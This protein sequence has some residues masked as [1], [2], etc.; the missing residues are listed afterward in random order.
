[1]KRD[2]ETPKPN[3]ILNRARKAARQK[4]AEQ[5]KTWATVDRLF[6]RDAETFGSGHPNPF[7][8]LCWCRKW[9]DKDE[10]REMLEG[11]T[12]REYL[13]DIYS[14]RPEDLFE[15]GW[16]FIERA[17][18]KKKEIAGMSWE[19]VTRLLREELPASISTVM[20]HPNLEEAHANDR[21]LGIPDFK[22]RILDG[23]INKPYLSEEEVAY[24]N[25]VAEVMEKVEVHP[26]PMFLPATY[27]G[28]P[29]PVKLVWKLMR[30][31]K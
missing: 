27:D 31:E 30:D 2:A 22:V 14:M 15:G 13:S 8:V 23:L 1:M 28:T 17:Y 7:E 12:L 19:D 26:T 25:R 21:A 16:D 6:V 18:Q 3:E 10:N 29:D 5:K 24:L 4:H 20:F 11:R 9:L